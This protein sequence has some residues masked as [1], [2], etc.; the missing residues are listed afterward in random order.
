MKQSGKLSGN[1]FS[2][3][4]KNYS[5][6]QKKSIRNIDISEDVKE[7]FI[8]TTRVAYDE[9]GNRAGIIESGSTGLSFVLNTNKK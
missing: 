2:S 7:Q 6:E 4:G 9:S 3:N 5:V 8:H 1:N